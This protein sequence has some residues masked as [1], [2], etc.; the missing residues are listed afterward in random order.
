MR[1]ILLLIGSVG[2]FIALVQRSRKRTEAALDDSS[3]PG[4][5]ARSMSAAA[6]SAEG[7]STAVNLAD[8]PLSVSAPGIGGAGTWE[9]SDR[10]VRS[11]FGDAEIVSS[12]LLVNGREVK[13]RGLSGEHV[14]TVVYDGVST[15]TVAAPESDEGRINLYWH[16]AERKGFTD[17]QWRA[18]EDRLTYGDKDGGARITQILV[19]GSVYYRA[20]DYDTAKTKAKVELRLR[21]VSRSSHLGA[22]DAA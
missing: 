5:A 2:G 16:D 7:G 1:A 8:G 11:S 17:G 9:H 3:A 6:Y 13:A 20:R 15:L 12:Q 10:H 4:D 18:S 19:D 22:S 21:Y 14:I